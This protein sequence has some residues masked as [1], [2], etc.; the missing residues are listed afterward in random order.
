MGNLLKKIINFNKTF[1]Y[2]K[3]TKAPRNYNPISIALG[4]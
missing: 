2:E 3:K 4:N 1:I